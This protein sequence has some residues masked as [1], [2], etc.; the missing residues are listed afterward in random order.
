MGDSFFG[1]SDVSP[2]AF[3]PPRAPFPGTSSSQSDT[4]PPR[5]RLRLHPSI[6]SPRCRVPPPRKS[7]FCA[8]KRPE[9][10]N[11]LGSDAPRL[12]LSALLARR[13]CPLQMHPTSA[14]NH[15][16]CKR[17]RY[18][19]PSAL[20]P[21]SNGK[22][23]TLGGSRKAGVVSGQPKI[24]AVLCA[25]RLDSSPAG[26]GARASGRNRNSGTQPRQ[27][28]GTPNCDHG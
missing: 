24:C 13:T 9:Q 4:P 8:D 11:C 7:L 21:V 25:A 14:T 20:E 10:A 16:S 28:R 18:L 23:A 2:S 5:L 6:R 15:I 12:Y 19:K 26:V 22:H 1:P 3:S 17:G 27:S